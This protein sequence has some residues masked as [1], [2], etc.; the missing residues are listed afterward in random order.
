MTD[1]MSDLERLA[2]LEAENAR[3][4][5]QLAIAGITQLPKA[6]LPYLE[7][8]VGLRSI[9]V[10]AYPQL[11]CPLEQ[12]QRCLL[13]FAYARRQPELNSSYFPT[14]WLDGASDW[15]RR[16]GHNNTISSLPA[17]VAAAVAS[18]VAYSDP[19]RF[20]HDIELGLQVGGVSKPNNDWWLV[21]GNGIA[22]PVPL[23]WPL[24]DVQPI[25][26]VS[27]N[28]QEIGPRT[29]DVRVTHK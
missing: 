19:H 21:L 24:V 7:Q 23:N 20:P 27:R 15:L 17:L 9:V 1:D 8:A 6:D 29:S 4:A 5:R 18:R 26:M 3:M 22:K 12:F 13:F 16:Q 2:Y 10:A 14:F 28:G 25:E 11:A